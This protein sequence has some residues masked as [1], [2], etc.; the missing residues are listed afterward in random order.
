V[1]KTQKRCPNGKKFGTQSPEKLIERN[2][3]KIDRKKIRILL[4]H[5]LVKEKSP[6]KKS[7]KQKKLNHTI[8]R[9]RT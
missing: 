9:I 2:L 3:P 1:K 8:S 4:L 6:G 5:I 7:S